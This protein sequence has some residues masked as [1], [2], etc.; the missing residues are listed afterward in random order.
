MSLVDISG[1]PAEALPRR[2]LLAPAAWRHPLALIGL[3]IAAFWIVVAVAV[4]IL[5]VHDPLAQDLVP[6]QGPAAAH[7][8]GTDELGRDVFSRVLWG[9]RL[10]LPVAL[11]LVACAVLIGTLLGAIAGYFGGFVD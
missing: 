6:L 8:F 5:P 7:W 2:R 11:A 10:S 4:P 1:V 9:A 3:V